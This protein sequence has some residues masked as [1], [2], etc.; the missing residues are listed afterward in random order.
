MATTIERPQSAQVVAH[1][2]EYP[3]D[4][5]G[6]GTGYDRRK[7]RNTAERHDPDARPA[8]DGPAV[9]I[10]A[11]SPEDHVLDGMEAYR[12]AAM[13]A[14]EPGIDHGPVHPM[15]GPVDWTPP[16]DVRHAYE[17]HGDEDDTHQVNVA[18]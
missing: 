12:A 6:D 16:E 15:R 5:D 10:D 17:D 8:E 1:A 13:R 14:M 9:L 7:Q 18:T 2:T 3:A 4:R 11:H